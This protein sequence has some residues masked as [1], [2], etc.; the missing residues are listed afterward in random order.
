MIIIEINILF[1][2]HHE[3][4]E[5][6]LFYKLN[7]VQFVFIYIMTVEVGFIKSC[8]ISFILFTCMFMN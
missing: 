4:H 2:P 6:M 7:V 3:R 5:F 1:E 8:V